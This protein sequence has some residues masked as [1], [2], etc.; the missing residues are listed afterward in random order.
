L[1]NAA[2]IDVFEVSKVALVFW[3]LIGAS[4]AYGKTD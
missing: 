2:Y 4:I 1:I 3:G